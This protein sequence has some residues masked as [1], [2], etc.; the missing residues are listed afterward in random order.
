MD[1]TQ[2]WILDLTFLSTYFYV[3]FWTEVQSREVSDQF[4]SN[5]MITQTLETY[6]EDF[7]FDSI[8]NICRCQGWKMILNP[9]TNIVVS[10]LTVCQVIVWCQVTRRCLP[11]Y[12][13]S[14]FLRV[15]WDNWWGLKQSKRQ[16]FWYDLVHYW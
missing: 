2:G 9:R 4:W 8:L 3:K 15:D 1:N 11:Q 7:L 5:F 6:L 10:S 13:F 12:T 14:Y 16:Y